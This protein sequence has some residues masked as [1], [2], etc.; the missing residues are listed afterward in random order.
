M[1][2]GKDIWMS[3]KRLRVTLRLVHLVAAVVMV[4]SSAMLEGVALEMTQLMS[5]IAMV[6]TGVW[7]W[8]QGRIARF[9]S[10]RRRVA[11]AQ[12]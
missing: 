11:V 8:Q 12:D 7:M 4:F 9:F 5:L 1:F 3:N 6:V 2:V 10:E